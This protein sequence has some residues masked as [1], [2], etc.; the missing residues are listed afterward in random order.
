MA[1]AEQAQGAA[2]PVASDSLLDAGP[3]MRPV[4]VA[5]QQSMREPSRPVAKHFDV[6]GPDIMVLA[7]TINKQTAHREVMIPLLAKHLKKAKVDD[8]MHSVFLKTVNRVRKDFPTQVPEYRSTMRY[9]VCL[10]KVFKSDIKYKSSVKLTGSQRIKLQL[11][12]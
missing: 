8:D 2:C 9:K 3:R 11:Q 5:N 10:N 4:V 12:R 1:S 7:A 6:S